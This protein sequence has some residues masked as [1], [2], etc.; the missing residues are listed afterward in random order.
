MAET[1]IILNC[2]VVDDEPLARRQVES[3]IARMPF[4]KLGG[5]VRNPEAAAAVLQ[6]EAVDLIFLDIRM[7]RIS[8]I[9]FLKQN[10]IFQQVILISAYPE[11][12]VEGF[13]LE[14][15]DYLVKPVSFERFRKACQK[16][17]A[18]VGGTQNIRSVSGQGDFLYVRCNQR[19]EK[20]QTA[21]I[22]YIESMLNY[23]HI[24]TSARKY[25]VYSSLKGVESSLP[26]GQF[27]RIHK[28]CIAAVAHIDA[29]DSTTVIIQGH[30]LPLSR[31]NRQEVMQLAVR[32]GFIK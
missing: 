21:E 10:E 5:S 26:A 18:R 23:V 13:E 3:Y 12:A 11:Y 9:D 19:F 22:L 20:I 8:G 31:R 16:A 7:P 28:S 30:E 15:T 4:L 29:I 25:T 24:V 6:S 27:I 14:V 2:L 17:L 32:M 1:D